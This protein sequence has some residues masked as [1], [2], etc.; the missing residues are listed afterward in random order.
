MESDRAA[1]P[2]RSRSVVSGELSS[3]TS[4]LRSSELPGSFLGTPD[5]AF[6]HA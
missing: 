5:T 1:L 3:V 4:L 2:L 6:F